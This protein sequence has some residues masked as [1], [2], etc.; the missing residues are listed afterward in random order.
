MKNLL[1]KDILLPN[2]FFNSAFVSI[3]IAMVLFPL[4]KDHEGI[5]IGLSGIINALIVLVF[6]LEFIKIFMNARKKN[7]L[8]I[9]MGAVCFMIVVYTIVA[10]RYG[11][12]L[13]LVSSFLAAMLFSLQYFF[14]AIY[15]V[16]H[17][18][19]KTLIENFGIY[20]LVL[21]AF[22]IVYIV[23]FFVSKEADLNTFS[24]MSYM[25]IAYTYM[26]ILIA[27]I[28]KM[29]YF[30]ENSRLLNWVTI[31]LFWI[32]IVYSGTRGPLVCTFGFF[33]L[34]II[35]EIIYQ[36]VQHI[37]TI[38]LV[39]SCFVIIVLFSIHVWSPATSGSAGRLQNFDYD[40]EIYNAQ[41]MDILPEK[42]I[43][44]VT[45]SKKAD[46][47]NEKNV[48]LSI[49]DIYVQYIL[50][51]DDNIKVSLK[52][53]KDNC[54]KDGEK[55]LDTDNKTIEENFRKYS[56]YQGRDLLRELAIDEFKKSPVWGNGAMYFISKYDNYPHNI[57]IEILCDFGILGVVIFLIL[58]ITLL[59]LNLKH[60]KNDNSVAFLIIL[61]ITW[62]ASF[63]LSDTMYN[64]GIWV[65]IYTFGIYNYLKNRGSK[66]CE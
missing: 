36:R 21:I 46:K 40:A 13:K 23:R 28:W 30:E 33:I 42:E 4:V 51:S 63:L 26:V 32:T 24:G 14:V 18:K 59:I 25:L 44:S 3:L 39:G 56:L 6:F 2:C 66:Q 50:E 41:K 55:I 16:E 38:L 58:M 19:A 27:I 65:F 8:F 5:R 29:L 11:I 31:F 34:L 53:L 47:R 12:S 57:V 43:K 7:K 48:A 9:S 64:G 15:I 10:F 62:A 60:I 61:S 35:Y 54:G 22:S 45:I 1:N 20:R 17:K 52:E 49:Q 37:K